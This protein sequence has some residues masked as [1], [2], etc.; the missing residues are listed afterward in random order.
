MLIGLKLQPSPIS[1]LIRKDGEDEDLAHGARKGLVE[2]RLADNHG[3]NSPISIH[4]WVSQ[5][6]NKK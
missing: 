6:E 3:T 2:L 5:V 1:D 4:V